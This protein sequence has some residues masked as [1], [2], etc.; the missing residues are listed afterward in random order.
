MSADWLIITMQRRAITTTSCGLQ[1]FMKLWHGDGVVHTTKDNWNLVPNLNA[2]VAVDNSMQSER[3]CSNR[4]LQ[5]LTDT[6]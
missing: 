2:L 3:F 5:F 6:G 4:M 1:T